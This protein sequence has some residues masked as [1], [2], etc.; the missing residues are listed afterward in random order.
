MFVP[1]FVHRYLYWIYV[2]LSVLFS[3]AFGFMW[4]RWLLTKRMRR[5]KSNT[6]EHH[7]AVDAVKNYLSGS[8]HC[9]VV[10]GL[11]HSKTYL[12]CQTVADEINQAG[13]LA[14]WLC[15]EELIRSGLSL[16][17]IF[18][19]RL[20]CRTLDEF[21]RYL[22]ERSCEHTWVIFDAV[23]AWTPDVTSFF[24][25]LIDLSYTCGKFRVLLFTHKTDLACS[26]LRWS[27][28]Q[29]PIQ[30]V[31]PIG[32]CRWSKSLLQRAND[33][34]VNAMDVCGGCPQIQSDAIAGELEALWTIGITRLTRFVRDEWAQSGEF[35]ANIAVLRVRV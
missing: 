25:E 31:E 5:S 18:L 1:E 6:E 23:N 11:F 4:Y 3:S 20:G 17:Q 16:K 8:E 13:G 33:Q 35:S 32:C 2:L 30:I 27:S 21:T 19:E 24:K 14:T 22:P 9:L 7:P 34:T 29:R 28:L 12:C 26:V 15:C 10:W